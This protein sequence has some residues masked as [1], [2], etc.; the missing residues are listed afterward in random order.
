MLLSN[1]GDDMQH[2]GKSSPRC[3]NIRI[4]SPYSGIVLVLS[5]LLA[6]AT[7]SPAETAAVIERDEPPGDYM[8]NLTSVVLD[9]TSLPPSP[10]AF[11][12]DRRRREQ[13]TTRR[14]TRR[15]TRKPTRKPSSK[16]TT[17]T[18]C[19]L[20]VK[21]KAWLQPRFCARIHTTELS[22]PRGLHIGI[23]DEI[24]LVERGKSRVV[25]LED[26]GTK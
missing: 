5:C 2:R 4:F 22:D 19:N 8:Q 16:P 10:P 13:G 26:D 21:S 12:N 23:N 11:A 7:S 18:A 20:Y 14:P 9:T 17:T 24:L 25:R 6:L 3:H 15:P 1:S